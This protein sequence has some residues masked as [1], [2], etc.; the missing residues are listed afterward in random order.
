M[1]PLFWVI[2][3]VLLTLNLNGCA[4]LNE[5]VAKMEQRTYNSYANQAL[6]KWYRTQFLPKMNSE[7]F[8][9]LWMY[10]VERLIT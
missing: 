3:I 1:K 9:L 5:W 7:K 4:S 2:A 6:V 8:I 10:V